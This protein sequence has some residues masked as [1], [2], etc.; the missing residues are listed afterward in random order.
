MKEKVDIEGP[1][2][3]FYEIIDFLL[4]PRSSYVRGRGPGPKPPSKAQQV[5]KEQF[6][7]AEERAK[8]A[9]KMNEELHK[10]MEELKARQTMMEIFEKL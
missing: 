8:A 5:V 4:P 9:E 2:M 10:Q 6:K 3:T 1:P 7:E